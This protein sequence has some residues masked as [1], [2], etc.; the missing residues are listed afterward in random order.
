MIV[1]VFSCKVTYLEGTVQS[2]KYEDSVG[3]EYKMVKGFCQ[4]P[5]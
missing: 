1:F 5:W 3:L 4:T 2:K